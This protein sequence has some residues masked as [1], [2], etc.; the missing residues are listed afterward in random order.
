MF[1]S[2]S[3]PR[4]GSIYF[5]TLLITMLFPWTQ[6]TNTFESDIQPYSLIL[7]TPLAIFLFLSKANIQK[8]SKTG[9][10]CL[11]ACMLGTLII[12]LIALIDGINYE[13]MRGVY[14]YAYATIFFLLIHSISTKKSH[15]DIYI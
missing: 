4:L 1:N 2:S 10:G 9:L 15:K 14:Q 11:L 3:N 12:F 5:S 13:S 6:L 8:T 7:A